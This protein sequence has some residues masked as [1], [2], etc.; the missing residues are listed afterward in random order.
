MEQL[1]KAATQQQRLFQDSDSDLDQPPPGVEQIH[2]ELSNEEGD[3]QDDNNDP[4]T[5]R[6]RAPRHSKSRHSN[7]KPITISFYPG[8]WKPLLRIAQDRIRRH[9]FLFQAFPSRDDDLTIATDFIADEI[10][11]AESNGITLD[12]CAFISQFHLLFPLT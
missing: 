1:E 12:H 8:A 9:I 4:E 11:R 7:P 6:K 5:P 10:A 2:E 3:E